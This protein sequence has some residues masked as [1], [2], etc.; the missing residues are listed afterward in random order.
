MSLLLLAAGVLVVL[1]VCV[2]VAMT[3]LSS[4][5]P[6]GPLATW[7]TKVVYGPLRFRA[8]GPG[9]VRLRVAGPLVTLA[10]LGTWIVAL[11]IGWTLIFSADANAAVS[12]TTGDPVGGWER[13]YFAGISLFTLGTGDVVAGDPVW[14]FASAVAAVNGLTLVTLSVTFVLPIVTA[15]THRHRLAARIAL[16]GET[17]D[18]VVLGFWDGR[19][20]RG[21]DA[22]LGGVVNDILLLAE[23]HHTYPILHYFHGADPVTAFPLRL[24]VLDEALTIMRHGLDPQVTPGGVM[25]GHARGAIDR[26]LTVLAD[27]FVPV[28][29]WKPPPPDLSSL[30]DR[31]VPTVEQANFDDAVAGLA[32]HRRHVAAF[33]A[34]DRWRW[35]DVISPPLPSARSHRATDLGEDHETP[36]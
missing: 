23:R 21:T 2:D 11:W 19:S 34:H 6:M 24:A 13:A 12:A 26:L 8:S 1:L 30:C 20:L 16:L 25:V 18:R 33:V 7:A 3:A 17:P 28:G 31:G 15:V 22:V 36:T 35:D 14:Q 5:S 32:G 4:G 9:D 27:A 29:S 10:V